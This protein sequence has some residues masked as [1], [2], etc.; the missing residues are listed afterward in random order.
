MSTPYIVVAYDLASNTCLG[1]VA[2]ALSM[3]QAV[4]IV[5]A[6]AFVALTCGSSLR[7]Y[8][9]DSSSASLYGP[10]CAVNLLVH[11]QLP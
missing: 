7:Y 11:W 6:F 9:R 2:V 4:S 3:E 1:I 8:V 10:E 5:K